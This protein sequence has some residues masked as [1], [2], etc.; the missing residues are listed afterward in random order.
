MDQLLTVVGSSL[1]SYGNRHMFSFAYISI[2]VN[3][4][5]YLT[6]MCCLIKYERYFAFSISNMRVMLPVRYFVI[7]SGYVD[8]VSI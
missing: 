5:V 3:I 1:Y 7:V 6:K 2:N 8:I 4:N